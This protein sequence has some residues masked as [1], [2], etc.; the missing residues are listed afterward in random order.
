MSFRTQ[1]EPD[2]TLRLEVPSGLPPGPADVVVVVQPNEAANAIVG[3][4][5]VSELHGI[6]ADKLPDVDLDAELREIRSA[7]ED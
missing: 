3:Q 1:I 6:W 7:W 4:R 2:G 5:G